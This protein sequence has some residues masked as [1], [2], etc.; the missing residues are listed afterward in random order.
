MPEHI[1]EAEAPPPPPEPLDGEEMANEQHE[2]GEV[3]LP[4]EH[5]EPVAPPAPVA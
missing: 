1:M 5:K 2:D 4:E 3:A